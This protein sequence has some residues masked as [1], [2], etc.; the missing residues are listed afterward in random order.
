MV[1][2][3]VADIA[4]R[5]GHFNFSLGFIGFAVGLG[6]TFSTTVAGWIA[7][8]LGDPAAFV[9]LALVGLAA[10][11]LVWL[12]MP[13]TRPPAEAPVTAASPARAA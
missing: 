13:E 11:L 6:A 7:D 2:L 12:A 5:S 9:A 10:T 3:V 1:P 8:K 4:G